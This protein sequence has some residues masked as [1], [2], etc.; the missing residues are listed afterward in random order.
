MNWCK[1]TCSSS[2]KGLQQFGDT[3]RQPEDATLII[4]ALASWKVFFFAHSG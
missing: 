4:L 3:A 2:T 1:E